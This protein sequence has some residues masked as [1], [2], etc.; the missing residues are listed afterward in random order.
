[1]S[2]CSRIIGTLFLATIIALAG[3]AQ[4]IAVQDDRSCPG[5]KE[6][7]AKLESGDGQ[8]AYLAYH[9]ATTDAERRKWLCIAANRGL[10]EAQAEIAHLHWQRPG[11]TP[12]PFERDSILAYAWTEIARQRGEPIAYM[13]ERLN[14][15]VKGSERCRAMALA[16]RWEP[17]PAQC[18]N[19]EESGYFSIETAATLTRTPADVLAAAKAGD[20][21]AAFLAYRRATTDAERR[22]W[23]CIAANR[24][25]PE[26]QAEI[27]WLHRRTP[28]AMTSPFAEDAFKASI[29][30]II[31]VYRHQPVDEVDWQ[32]VPI[33]PGIERWR[34]MAWARRWQPDP[35]S[36][37][38]MEDSPYFTIAPDAAPAASH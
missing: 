3:C 4:D 26:A 6:I 1:M 33:V 38:N 19:M 16:L 35:A 37:E 7:P 5:P 22:K 12:S 20:A 29:W 25:L 32:H 13:K 27:A 11:A 15:V 8:A 24:D 18:E 30:S 31:A 36:C 17:D 9:K 2:P 14:M 21:R 34:A 10:P 28:D 23:V